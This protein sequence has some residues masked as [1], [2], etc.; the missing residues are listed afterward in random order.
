[1]I[2]VVLNS[3]QGV[4]FV[5]V[6]MLRFIAQQNDLPLTAALSADRKKID[7][8]LSQNAAASG[9][10]ELMIEPFQDFA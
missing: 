7:N 2:E 3:T 9:S 4:I 10:L 8:A 1:L 6:I 5:H